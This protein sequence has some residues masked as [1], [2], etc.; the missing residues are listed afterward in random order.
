MK[1]IELK[2]SEEMLQ[3]LFQGKKVVFDNYRRPTIML[4]PPRYGVFTTYDKYQEI[5]RR[6]EMEGHT[7]AIELLRESFDNVQNRK[8]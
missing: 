8:N 4:Y 3:A 6:A 7:R 2:I 1:D 5:V